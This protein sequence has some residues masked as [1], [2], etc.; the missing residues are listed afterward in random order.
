MLKSPNQA[1]SLP[2]PFIIT[3]ITDNH[4]NNSKC[5][6]T[7]LLKQFELRFLRSVGNSCQSSEAS[8]A[9]VCFLILVLVHTLCMLSLKAYLVF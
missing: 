8:E 2:S 1:Q 9:I 6:L 5:C 4:S 7:C 3:E